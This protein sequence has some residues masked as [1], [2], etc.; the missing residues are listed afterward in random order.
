MALKSVQAV[1]LAAGKSSRFKTGKTKLVEK[2]VD[3]EMILYPTS[4][5]VRLKASCYT[6]RRISKKLLKKQ[7]INNFRTM[8]RL[9]TKQN[10]SE[11]GMLLRVHNLPGPAITSL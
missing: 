6:C 7:S 1:I 10:N 9:Y 11:Q 5:L 2:F 8:L 3:K 4:L